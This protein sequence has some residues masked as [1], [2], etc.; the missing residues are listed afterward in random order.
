MKRHYVSKRRSR[1]LFK[2]TCQTMAW[3]N[4]ANFRGGVRL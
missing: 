1:R 3:Q 2:C 4:F